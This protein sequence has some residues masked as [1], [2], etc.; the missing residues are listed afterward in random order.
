MHGEKEEYRT[1]HLAADSRQGFPTYLVR[2]DVLGGALLPRAH[3]CRDVCLS[4]YQLRLYTP[5]LCLDG[6]R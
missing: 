3:G 2:L 5:H 6:S 1:N 4:R